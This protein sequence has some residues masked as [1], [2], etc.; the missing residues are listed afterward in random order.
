MSE[1]DRFGQELYRAREDKASAQRRVFE[2]DEKIKQ[3]Q[4]EQAQL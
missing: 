1:F 3:L 4:D 2:S